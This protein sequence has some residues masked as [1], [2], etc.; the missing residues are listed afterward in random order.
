MGFMHARNAD[1]AIV[2]GSSMNTAP[3]SDMPICTKKMVLVNL[4]RTS[5]DRKALVFRTECDTFMRELVK[6]FGISI[7]PFTYIQKFS[8]KW[9][10]QDGENWKVT[11]T[12]HGTNEPP[13]CIKVAE[14]SYLSV[15]R[16]LD[17]SNI[18]K[19]FSMDLRAPRGTELNFSV[20]FLDEYREDRMSF[21]LSLDDDDGC[22]VKVFEK[23]QSYE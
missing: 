19:N 21:V 18:T 20:Q 11:I 8:V 1:L 2:L 3:F 17:Q 5:Y 15:T 14:V 13:T 9:N 12:G 16:E 10:T 6:I 22:L 7:P 23:I 4:G